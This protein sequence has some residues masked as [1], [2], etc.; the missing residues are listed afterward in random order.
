MAFQLFFIENGDC[1]F[2]VVWH[3]KATLLAQHLTDAQLKQT[4]RL[5]SRLKIASVYIQLSGRELD[6]TLARL[7]GLKVEQPASGVESV[8]ICEWV[9]SS[10]FELV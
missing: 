1:G 7:A 5:A 9:P 4:F 10:Q 3:A 8:K 6:P 2:A